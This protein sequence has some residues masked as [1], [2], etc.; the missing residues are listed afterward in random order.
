[1]AA[2]STQHPVFSFILNFLGDPPLFKGK[3]L[4]ILLENHVTLPGLLVP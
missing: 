2:Y 1:M 4:I 3:E